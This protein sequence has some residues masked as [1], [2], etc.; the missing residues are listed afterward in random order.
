M[1]I[2][3]IQGPSSMKHNTFPPRLVRYQSYCFKL[4]FQITLLWII[5]SHTSEFSHY[6]P[7]IYQVPHR[8]RNLIHHV[9]CTYLHSYNYKT[10]CILITLLIKQLPRNATQSGLLNIRRVFLSCLLNYY[11]CQINNCCPDNTPR[12]VV[13]S[14]V[15][16]VLAISSSIGRRHYGPLGTLV[17]I[18]SIRHY[19]SGLVTGVLGNQKECF[20]HFTDIFVTF[21]VPKLEDRPH[22]RLAAEAVFENEQCTNLILFSQL[23]LFLWD[24]G[25]CN[26]IPSLC[27]ISCMLLKAQPDREGKFIA[28]SWTEPEDFETLWWLLAP[29]LEHLKRG[30]FAEHAWHLCSKKIKYQSFQELLNDGLQLSHQETVSLRKSLGHRLQQGPLV[31]QWET[32]GAGLLFTPVRHSEDGNCHVWY[33]WLQ[34]EISMAV[35]LNTA[36]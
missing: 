1:G 26:S 17:A 20:V 5:P 12:I 8:K 24:A 18:W 28:K 33:G 30:K 7:S 10:S 2:N 21:L 4:V 32:Q 6:R 16:Q 29:W 23:S 25:I 35:H 31:Q 36:E 3:A 13:L 22:P 15:H 9:L 27:H 19:F 14:V 11:E 34:Q